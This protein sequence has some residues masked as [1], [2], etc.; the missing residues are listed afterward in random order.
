MKYDE[1][2][3]WLYSTQNFGIKLGLDA[4]KK[5]LRQFLANPTRDT[6]VVHIAGTNGKGSTC[7]MID[8]LARSTGIR[9]GIFTS[10]H[11]VD[12]R[13]RIRV[14]G[15]MIP[16]DT[17]LSYLTELKSLVGDWEHHPTF[18]ELTLAVAMK[19]F[20]A[21]ECELIILETGM[22][23]R[24]DATTAVPADVCV[25]T[26]IA[27]D[28]SDWLGDTIEKVAAEKA[29]IICDKKPIISSQQERDA[30]IVIAEVADEKRAPLTKVSGPLLGYSIK[31]PGI[32]QAENAKVAIEAMHA[33]EIPLDFD[34]VKH[35]L[36]SITWPG[37]FETISENPQIIIDGAHNPHAAAA[38]VE[39]WQREFPSQ[40]ATLIF[41]AVESKDI[42]GVLTQ[43]CSISDSIHITPIDSPRSLSPEELAEALP[44]SAPQPTVHASLQE[45]L[46]QL[47]THPH[48]ILIAGSLFLIGQAKAILS[49]HTFQQSSQ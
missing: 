21:T 14:N 5:L 19:Y 34:T 3:E 48:P 1:A 44:T 29:G 9:C 49:N 43:L 25:I 6:K 28:H 23:G 22:G 30:E 45:C 4:P 46:A 20:K 17:V 7:A 38:L 11:L 42:G 26:P 32:H 36:S 2:L 13:E 15:E 33:L 16:E 41:G 35:A 40:K 31:L 27:L 24:L 18:F 39:T 12:Y 37:R 10:P 47:T 8:A